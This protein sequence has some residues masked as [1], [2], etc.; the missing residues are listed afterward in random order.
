MTDYTP[1]TEEVANAYAASV[2]RENPFGTTRP[3][4]DF[5][6]WLKQNNNEVREKVAQE[7]EA[8]ELCT[9]QILLESFGVAINQ[10]V[11]IC[12]RCRYAILTRGIK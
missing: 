6:R 10:G 5:Y 12:H 1:T 4:Q 11:P 8:S 3:H 7:I 2:Y 9:C